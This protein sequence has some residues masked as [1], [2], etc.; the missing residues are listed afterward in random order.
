M[1]E[2]FLTNFN[3]HPRQVDELELAEVYALTRK[4]KDGKR[5]FSSPQAAFEEW[6]RLKAAKEQAEHALL[7]GK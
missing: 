7:F 1:N 5:R 2:L 4:K 6:K 3:M